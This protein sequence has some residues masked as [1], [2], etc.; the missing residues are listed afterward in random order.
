MV[1][2]KLFEQRAVSYQSI[3]ASGDDIT[4][5]TYAGTNINAD[6][7]YTV[8]AVFSA[9]NLISTTLST[10]PLDVFIRDDG[11]RK[12]FRPKPAWV[13]R[14]DVDLTREATAASCPPVSPSRW[15][16]AQSW[17]SW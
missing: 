2:N 16:R 3:F 12:P 4:F 7:A 9:V 17:A 15:G 5:G 8:N 10:L 14:P 6:T 1:F 11:T 13:N